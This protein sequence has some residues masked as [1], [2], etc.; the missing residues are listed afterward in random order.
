ML[1]RLAHRGKDH[2]KTI[3]RHNVTMLASWSEIEARP[4]S[5]SLQTNAVW[6]GISAPKPTLEGL[7][8]WNNSFA[9]AAVSSGGLLLARDALGVRPLYY[10]NIDGSLAFASEVKA[11]LTVTE[12]VNEFPPGT[13]YTPQDGFKRFARV[14]TGKLPY[15]DVDRTVVELRRKL[16]NAITRRIVADEMGTW[17]SGGVDSSV[18]ATLARRH[19]KVLHSFVSGVEG[20]PDI[21]YGNQM[22]EFLGTKHHVLTLTLDDLL[23][24]L[25]EVIYHLESFDAL[26]VRSS[27]ASYLTSKMVGDYVGG[28]LSGEGGDELFAG[29]D[30]IK[31][32][33]AEKIPEELIDIVMRLHNTALQRVDRCA[34]AHGVVPFVPFADKDVVEYALSIPAKYKI[35]RQAGVVIEKWILRKAVEGMLPDSVLWRA[36]AKFWQGAGVK[37]LLA[38]HAMSLISDRDFKRERILPNGWRLNSKEELMYYRI[39]KEHFGQISRLDWMGRTKGSPVQ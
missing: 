12:D 9:L 39:F 3:D 34:N 23:S 19:V 2:T 38:S 10:G 4:V 21:A 16:E 17:L 31:R 28:V 35:Y 33:A 7:T 8:Q 26:L 6:D 5:C 20:A 15:D 37:E 24:A 27:V 13:W 29:Y 25:P 36:K 14:R 32:I 11:L 22:A 1:E 18:I 30:Y